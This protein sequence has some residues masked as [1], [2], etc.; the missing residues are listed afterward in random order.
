MVGVPSGFP[1]VV[2][3]AGQAGLA[4]SY[5]LTALGVEHLLGRSWCAPAPI[6]GPTAPRWRP[7]SP[8]TCW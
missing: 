7:G 4:V 5:E 8:M 6:S 1:V 3:G 2:V